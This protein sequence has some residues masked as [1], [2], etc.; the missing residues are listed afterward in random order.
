MLDTALQ[1]FQGAARC[2][3]DSDEEEWLIHYMLGKISEKR[4]Q[5]PVEYLRLYKKV[6][7]EMGGRVEASGQ[8]RPV[9]V[10]VPTGCLFCVTRRLTTCT[11]KPPG[12]PGKSTTTTPRTWPWRPWR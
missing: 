7:P 5:A 10:M 1:C 8:A 11:K 9:G 4:K 3:C 6:Q 2:E 12:T